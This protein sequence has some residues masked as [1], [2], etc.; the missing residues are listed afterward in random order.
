M[1]SSLRPT[2]SRLLPLLAAAMSINCQVKTGGLA[3]LLGD[4]STPPSPD[5]ATTPSDAA[6]LATGG[7]GAG[8]AIGSTAI[9]GQGPGPNTGGSSGS[10]VASSGGAPAL[11]G[12]TSPTGGPFGSGGTGVGTTIG[13]GGRLGPSGLGGAM[14]DAENSQRDGA[15]LEAPIGDSPLSNPD[16]GLEKP[17]TASEAAPDLDQGADLQAPSREVADG[18]IRRDAEIEALA[19]GGPPLV[20][21]DEFEGAARTAPDE[22]KWSYATWGPSGGVNNEKQQY[23]TSLDNV[24]LNGDG[25]L[26]IRALKSIGQNAGAQYTSGRIH[27]KGNFS[28]T[29]GRVEVRAKLPAGVGSFP[30]IITMGTEGSWPQCGELA[31]VEQYGQDKSWFYSSAFAD[32]SDKSG[33]K[34]SVRYDFEN[35]TT[36]SADFHVYSVDRYSDHLVFQVDGDEV[37]RTS[38][39]T[40]SPFY[41]TPEYIILDVAVGGNM[42]GTIDPEGFPMDLVVD[43]VRV[44][45]F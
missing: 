41:T 40:S 23:T 12:A 14:Q 29:T 2:M 17:A 5:S 37:M 11:D 36:A 28:F 19:D 22:G 24:F 32:N 18:R 9:D 44:Y 38:Y 27:T 6:S 21:H 39:D 10:T 30:G 8:G 35:A 3:G 4:A 13:T 20:W 43:Y 25:Q 15:G 45:G 42:G 33:D 34:R 7:Q 1:A 26:V 31:L 16:L